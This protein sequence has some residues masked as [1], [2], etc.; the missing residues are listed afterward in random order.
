MLQSK[1]P[2]C[3]QN[4]HW[5]WDSVGDDVHQT[6]TTEQARSIEDAV[7]RTTTRANHSDVQLHIGKYFIRIIAGKERRSPSR[8]KMD[9]ANNP[10]FAKKNIPVIATYWVIMLLATLCTI[11]A[12]FSLFSQIS[13]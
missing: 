9:Q 13:I 11:A 6:L 2:N 5:F 7:N 10:I 1:I 4:L 3:D 12:F 8:L